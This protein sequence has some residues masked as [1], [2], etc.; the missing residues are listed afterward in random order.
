[1]FRICRNQLSLF[2]DA[3]ERE[4]GDAELLNRDDGEVFSNR[5]KECVNF[6]FSFH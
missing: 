5:Q 3:R 4:G 6:E 2:G 1:M